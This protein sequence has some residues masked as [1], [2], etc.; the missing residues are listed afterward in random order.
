M[1]TLRAFTLIELLVVVAIIALLVSILLPALSTA[2]E[3]AREAVCKAHEHSLYL[4]FAGYQNDYNSIKM[5]GLAP[6]EPPEMEWWMM[7]IL[8]YVGQNTEIFQ[9]PSTP[10]NDRWMFHASVFRKGVLY[11]MNDSLRQLGP[12]LEGPYPFGND[13][14]RAKG[15]SEMPLLGEVKYGL[16]LGPP[17]WIYWQPGTPWCYARFYHRDGQNFLYCDG[18]VEWIFQ[19]TA[20]DAWGWH[21]SSR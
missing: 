13:V 8:P 1:K 11:A 14:V 19:P 15:P 18:H 12:R 3:A 21:N 16:M 2:R 6:G 7:R 17:Y 9:C 5:A 4:A 10:E 20:E